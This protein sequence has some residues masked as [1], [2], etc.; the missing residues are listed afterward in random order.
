MFLLTICTFC[1]ILVV[2]SLQKGGIKMANT[3]FKTF[4]ISRG[5][6]QAD[7]AQKLGVTPSAY[8]MYERGERIPRDEI[9]IKI[10]SYYGKTVQE[11]FYA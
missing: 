1:V 8:A 10:A 2:K 3:R 9:K 7:M 11:L 6:T 5:L 4:R